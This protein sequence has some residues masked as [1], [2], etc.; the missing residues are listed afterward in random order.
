MKLYKILIFLIIIAYASLG[1]SKPRVTI[2][3]NPMLFSPNQTDVVTARTL[4]NA[5]NIS[6]YF[7]NTGIFDQNTTSG[8]TAGFEWPK[9]SGKTACFTAGLCI[10]CYITDNTGLSRMGQVMASYKGE[11]VPGAVKVVGGI[12]TFDNDSKFKMYVVRTGDNSSTNSDYAKWSLMVPYGAPYN[13]INNNGVYDDGVDV[14]GQKNAGETIFLC[15]TDADASARASGEGFGG[16]VTSPL[17][18]AEIHFTAWAYNT[19]GLEDL[20]FVN[21]VIINKGDSAWRNTYT[22]VVV[23]PD[24]GNANDDYIGSD[25]LN[26]IN[27]GYCYNATNNDA[28]YGA[29][30]PA[31]GM[32]YFKSPIVRKTGVENDTL[33][34]TSFTFFTNTG[35]SPPPCESDPNGESAPA[36]L[37]LKGV[38]KDGSPFLDPTQTPSVQTKYCYTGDPE[39]NVGWTESKGCIQNC[40]GTT[41]TTLGTNP[42]GDRR[43]IFASGRED[44]V[45]YSGDTQNIVLAQFVARGTSNLNSVTKLK[46]LAKTAKTIYLS[47]FNVTPPPTAP[48]VTASFTP[49]TTNGQCNIVLS[50]DDAAESYK[51]WDTIFYSKSDS[52][53]YTFEGYEVYELSKYATSYPDF[54]KPE[55]IDL[56]QATLIDIFDIKDGIKQLIDTFSTG[57]TVNGTEQFSPYPIVPAYKMPTPSSFPDIGVRRGITL[58]GTKFS[59]N[60]GDVSNFVY[61]QE[62]QFAVI[63]YGVTKS[64]KINRGFR[65]I[66]NSLTSS[67]IK[68]IPIKPPA[69]TVFTYYNGDTINTS[70]HDLGCMPIIRNQDLLK[71]ATYRIVFNPLTDLKDTTYNILRKLSTSSN[72]DTIKTKLKFSN[73][74]SSA[75]DSSRTIDGILFKMTRIRWDYVSPDKVNGARNVGVIKDV[76]T[77]KSLSRDSVQARLSGWE[78]KPANHRFLTGSSYQSDAQRPWQSVSMSI[79]YPC[80]NVYTDV[81]SKLMPDKLRKVKIVFSNTN[82]QYA[83]RYIDT[84]YGTSLQKSWKYV[85]MVEVPFKVYECDYS[86]STKTDVQLNCG[87]IESDKINPFTGKWNPTADTNGGNL[88]LLIFGSSY[89]V[90]R[91]DYKSYNNEPLNIFRDMNTV[92]VMYAWAPRLITEG[93]T[94]VDNDEFYI[95]PYGIN[96][97][98]IQGNLPFYYEFDVVAPKYGDVTNAKLTN[99]LDKIKV[100]PNPYYGFSKLDRS[101]SDKFVTFRNLP[102]Q[103]TIKIYTLNGDLIRT[104]VKTNSGTTATSSTIEWNL[105]NMENTPVA[106]GIYIALIDAPNIG[107]KVVKMAIFTAQERI[108][109]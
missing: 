106:S 52:N 11:Y 16:G 25:T 26:K 1:Y 21:W 46:S 47:N 109:F 23:D 36:Y 85:N 82:K 95:Y 81:Q 105:Q 60:Y 6:S 37:M 94:F 34:L 8:N 58:T 48:T 29:A 9:S 55:S 4:L 38:K 42:K 30:P 97:P 19:P 70:I 107:Q 76:N 93:A 87:F 13:D 17:L 61:G 50:W 101:K 89:D 69:G 75:D 54:T 31:F 83:Y 77:T 57:V 7:Q 15:M 28:D 63:A 56:T 65:V 99:A 33:G 108:N 100:V 32:D 12:P 51:Y 35:S 64:N 22:G 90:N 14:P 59:G 10:G 53:I 5:N 43:F 72:F 44:F 62:Y 49:L 74:F 18:Y 84:V 80:K 24:L 96:T 20:Q 27:L 92:D 41:G 3:D 91:N 67:I 88:Q 68:V 40:G 45:I 73:Y 104:L 78:Y 98:Y 79:A 86:D 39:T 103:C 71:T 102:L 66:R 2:G